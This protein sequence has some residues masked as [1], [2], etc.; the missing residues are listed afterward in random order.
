M[1]VLPAAA[2]LTAFM[3]SAIPA[4]SLAVSTGMAPAASQPKFEQIAM[5]GGGMRG[6]GGGMRGGGMSR[7]GGGFGG[8]SR[9]I[10]SSASGNVNFNGNRNFDRN[11]NVNRNTN[12]NVNNNIHGDCLGGCYNR[13]WD[14]P[15]AA[16]AAV[17][18]A[19]V[20][21]A[22][23]VGSIAYSLPPDCSTPT[24]NGYYECDGTW[25]QPQYA[26][27]DVQY[28]VVNPPQ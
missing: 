19:A 6:G 21:T 4:H 7:G 2:A 13:G 16:A 11:T 28:V 12:I 8:G 17:T 27:T 20:A 26:G 15:V 14:H 18:A 10:R 1:K 3:L 9:D 25:Y 22:A 23:V 24:A 5:R